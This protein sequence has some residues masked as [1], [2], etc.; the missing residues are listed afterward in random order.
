MVN[1]TSQRAHYAV[2]YR[3]VETCGGQQQ[4]TGRASR[5]RPILVFTRIAQNRPRST[6]GTPI[7]GETCRTRG[8][9]ERACRRGRRVE[10]EPYKPASDQSTGKSIS[11]PGT[12][13]GPPNSRRNHGRPRSSRSSN[14]PDPEGGCQRGRRTDAQRCA[15]G[16]A[17]G[18][19]YS[20]PRHSLVTRPQYE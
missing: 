11:F 14:D 13:H 9:T 16:F 19:T 7:C 1:R 17:K 15:T 10:P 3:D 20:P 8:H 18:R 4:E 5:K 2:L 6:R 12:H